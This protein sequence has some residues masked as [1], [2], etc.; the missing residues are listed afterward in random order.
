MQFRRVLPLLA[1]PAIALG[2][3]GVVVW[4]RAGH[5]LQ[6]AKIEQTHSGELPFELRALS[7]TG[8]HRFE[9]IATPASFTSAAF[10]NGKLYISSP[11][12]LYAYDAEGSPVHTW[13]VGLDLPSSALGAIAVA[14]LRGASAPQLVVAT[15][16]EGVLILDPSGAIHQLRASASEAREVTAVLPLSNGDL[17]IGTRRDGLLAYTGKKLTLFHPAFAGLSITTLAASEDGFWA[18]T[19]N[20][21][22]LHFSG[23]TVDS[24]GVDRGIPDA[25]ITSLA[26]HG[27]TVFAGTPVGVG[28]FVNGQPQRLFG[29]DLFAQALLASAHELTIATIDE[30]LRSVSLDPHPHASLAEPLHP[31]AVQSFTSPPDGSIYAVMHD[32]VQ[33]RDANGRWSSVLEAPVSSLTDGNVSALA[34]DAGGALWVGYFDRGI[35][36]VTADHTR[37]LEDDHLYCINRMVLDPTRHTMVVATANGLVLFDSNGKP[38]QTMLRRDGL[39]ADHVTDVVFRPDGMTLATPAGL[40]FVDDGQPPQSIYAFQGLANNHVYALGVRPD[41][42]TLAGTLGG[43]SLVQHEAVA[44]NITASNSGLKHNWITAITSDSHDG[45]SVGTYGAG[46]MQVESSGAVHPLTPPFIVNPN[47]MLR[48][49]THLFVGSLDQGLWM[50]TL[51]TGRWSNVNSGLPSRNVT[52]LAERDGFVYIGTDNGLVRASEE[53]IGQ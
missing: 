10:F 3:L 28:Q 33:R 11:S 7:T 50:E 35:D 46:V 8:N 19:R 9:P 41:G 20:T 24:F 5:V 44:R 27:N 42:D 51:S 40:T 34:F 12:A 22:V 36:I 26:V 49:A 15:A 45:W 37:H 1:L 25:D 21:G 30:G 29:K 39:I 18:G 17:L 32:H 31:A 4:L 6:Q 53:S 2:A 48:T 13:R 52:A 47:A 43:L 16:N 38:R 14:Q 23:G